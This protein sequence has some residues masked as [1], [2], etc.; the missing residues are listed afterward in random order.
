MNERRAVVVGICE[1]RAPYVTFSIVYAKYSDAMKYANRTRKQLLFVLVRTEPGQN[2]QL[3]KQRIT[4][5]TG[6]AALTW[7]EFGG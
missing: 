1:A 5:E 6:L 2:L 3:L 4:E 7:R